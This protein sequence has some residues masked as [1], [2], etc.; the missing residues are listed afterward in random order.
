[1]QKHHLASRTL[2]AAP[3]RKESQF[4]TALLHKPLIETLGD[5]QKVV[6]GGLSPVE[7]L[8]LA[9]LVRIKGRF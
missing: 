5:V 7:A 9:G 1:M 6:I 4:L 8:L 2:S 3:I